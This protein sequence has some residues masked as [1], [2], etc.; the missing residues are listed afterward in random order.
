[1]LKELVPVSV[2]KNLEEITAILN[3]IVQYTLNNT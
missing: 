1:M 3:Q 2:R